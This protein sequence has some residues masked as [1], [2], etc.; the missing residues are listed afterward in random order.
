MAED[1]REAAGWFAQAAQQ[2]YPRAQM[3]MGVCFENGY[4]VGCSRPWPYS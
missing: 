1:D 4:G 2:G 3:L